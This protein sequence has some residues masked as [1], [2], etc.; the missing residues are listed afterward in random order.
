MGGIVNSP[1]S[2]QEY[3]QYKDYAFKNA[4]DMIYKP[5]PAVDRFLRNL[6]VYSQGYFSRFSPTR[7]VNLRA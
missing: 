1:F 2:G 3:I 4:T 5:D 7:A 6:Q